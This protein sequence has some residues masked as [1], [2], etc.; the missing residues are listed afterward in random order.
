M[1]WL[2][3]IFS[4][5]FEA[6][7]GAVGRD[8]TPA[9]PPEPLIPPPGFDSIERAE[10][11]R[12]GRLRAAE[13]ETPPGPGG[14][15]HDRATPQPVILPPPLPPRTPQASDPHD[16]AEN[17][18]AMGTQPIVADADDVYDDIEPEPSTR[19]P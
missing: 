12:L 18:G 8:T 6:I 7:A 1:N 2:T 13:A 10:R 19:R 14:V 11:E 17:G 16:R 4:A 5:L 15:E 9:P 3:S